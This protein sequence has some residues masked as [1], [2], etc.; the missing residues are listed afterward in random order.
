MGQTLPFRYFEIDQ[1]DSDNLL[2]SEEGHQDSIYNYMHVYT[3][4]IR[5]WGAVQWMD[6]FAIATKR[7]LNVLF[8]SPTS[9]F[10]STI[11]APVPSAK[12]IL[13]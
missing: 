13:L 7:F 4:N 2:G 1:R 11:F 12:Y 10:V 9:P 3:H 8:L 5:T 6:F